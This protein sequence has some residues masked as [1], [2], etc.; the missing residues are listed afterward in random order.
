MIL[1]CLNSFRQGAAEDDAFSAGAPIPVEK[2]STWGAETLDA[3]L[4]NRWVKWDVEPDA[5]NAGEASAPS[6]SGAM[7][8]AA[9]IA[10]ALDTFGVRI[11]KRMNDENIRQQIARL[12]EVAM[13]RAVKDARD[14]AAAASTGTTTNP[15]PPKDPEPPKGDDTENGGAGASGDAPPLP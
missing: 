7:D 12:E 8:K 11:D 9:M 5:P 15:E 2:Y 13:A 3:R 10:Y 14:A 1:V 6:G 4:A